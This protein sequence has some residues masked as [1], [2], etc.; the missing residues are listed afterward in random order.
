MVEYVEVEVGGRRAS[1]RLTNITFIVGT[2][3]TT[4]LET[5]YKII[6]NIG[7]NVPKMSKDVNVF[8]QVGDVS[9]NFSF[10]KGR[11][12]QTISVGGEEVVF[13]WVPSK[14]IHRLIK[15]IDVSI[16]SADVIMPIIRTQEHV[17]II[18]EED[19]EQLNNLV[20][21]ARRRFALDVLYIGP[22]V[23]PRSAVDASK[24]STKLDQHG[25]NLA[26]V[27]SH[28]AL[29]KPNSFDA[30]KTHVKKLGLSLAVGLAKPGKIGAVLYG[31]SGKIPLSKAPCSIKMFLTL[32]TAL[33]LAP[34]VLFVENFDYCLTPKI[35]EALTP[36]F[37]QKKT[38]VVAE[39]HREEVAEWIKADKS[40]IVVDL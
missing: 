37:R 2:G 3:K 14:S 39:I 16:V 4:F 40:T 22:Y 12:R 9:Y 18:A 26:Q 32:A 13:E 38:R 24:P 17:S 35:A 27:L 20:L 7:K 10:D 1:A 30:I 31:K 5:L 36:L 34:H 28:L 23:D 33:E 19:L 29:H 15:P 11:V 21:T 25:K 6:S 8:I